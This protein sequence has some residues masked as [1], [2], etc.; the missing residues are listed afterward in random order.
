MGK[1]RR[2]KEKKKG[3][4]KKRLVKRVAI[5]SSPRRG[6]SPREEI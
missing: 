5:L 6:D 4:E 2:K 1:G 3:K